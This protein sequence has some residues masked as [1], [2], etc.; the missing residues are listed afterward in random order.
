MYAVVRHYTGQGA[1]QL[2]DA[3][4]ERK[5]DVEGVIR[6]VSGLVS[7]TMLRTSDGGISVTVCQDKAGADESIRLAREWISQNINAQTNPPVIS[8]GN[9]IVQLTG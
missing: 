1:S 6:G 7:Y 5:D 9:T 2:F 3:L 4:E 8:E